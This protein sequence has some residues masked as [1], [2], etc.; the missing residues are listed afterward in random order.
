VR[1]YPELDPTMLRVVLVHSGDVVLPEL[2]ERLGRYTEEKLRSRGIEL[3]LG[4]RVTGYDDWVVM[5]SKGEP[6]SANT[7]VWTAGVTPAPAVASLP[8]EKIRGRVKVNEYLEISGHEAVVWAVGDCAAVPNGRGGLHPPTAQH[9]LREGLAAAKN[10]EAAVNGAGAKPFRFSTLGQLASIGHH[11]G[12]AQILG[13]RFSGFMAWW[14]WR[15]V[16]LVKLPGIA[17]KVRVAMQW[18]L[19]LLFSRQI[20]QFL[21]LRDLEQIELLAAQV[22]IG[23][24]I[25]NSHSSEPAASRATT[26]V[27]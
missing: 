10:I 14:L 5:L 2:G 6:I 12:V 4:G 22:R 9:G 26:C 11:T 13:M 23:R 3:Q 15:S 19:D 21:T 17:K 27:P 8:V 18:T 7:L 24:S 16:Y 25:P 1:H 20:E